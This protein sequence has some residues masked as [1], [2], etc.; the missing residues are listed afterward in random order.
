MMMM[1]TMTMCLI[2]DV[3]ATVFFFTAVQQNRSVVVVLVV[4]KI[5]KYSIIDG[6]LGIVISVNYYLFIIYI[7][8][9]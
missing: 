8:E 4:N 2:T 7:F 3:V 9:N 1:S 5:N 6:D